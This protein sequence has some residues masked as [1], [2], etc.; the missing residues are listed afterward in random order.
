M[1]EYNKLL[2]ELVKQSGQEIIDRAEE[3]VGES[4]M[5]TDFY[6][7]LEFPQDSIPTIEA[8]KSV[9]NRQAYKV[10]RGDDE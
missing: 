3:L 2:I 8:I 1:T 10:I 7:R 9:V 6:I 4:E 5:I